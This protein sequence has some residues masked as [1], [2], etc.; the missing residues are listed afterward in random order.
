MAKTEPKTMSRTTA[1]RMMPRPVPPSGCLSACSAMRPDTATSRW[2]PWAVSAASTK[3]LAWATSTF[4][5]WTSKVTL[6]NAVCP[7]ALTWWGAG[8]TATVWP[9]VAPGRV[10]AVVANGDCNVVTWGIAAT[11][12]S[13]ASTEAVFSGEVTGVP[14]V[15]WSTMR[16]WS[17]ACFGAAVWSS[18]S[19]SVDSV[20]GSEKLLL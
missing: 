8:T 12:W 7:S 3:S 4:W 18:W 9:D 16:S 10:V 20:W 6:T 11:F 19:A 15:V 13:M 2:G 1:A 5:L 17:P 14:S